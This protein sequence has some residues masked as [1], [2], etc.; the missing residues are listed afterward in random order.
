MV[1]CPLVRYMMVIKSNYLRL[2]LCLHK[3]TL[4]EHGHLVHGNKHSLYPSLQNNLTT[5]LII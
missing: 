5:E 2:F 1:L 3:G 4:V